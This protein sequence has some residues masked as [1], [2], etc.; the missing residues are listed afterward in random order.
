MA[1]RAAQCMQGRCIRVPRRMLGWSGAVAHPDA[2]AGGGGPG[3]FHTGDGRIGG[4]FEAS[5]Q[6]DDAKPAPKE[7]NPPPATVAGAIDGITLSVQTDFVDVEIDA[8]VLADKSN[9]ANVVAETTF[10]TPKV[11]DAFF[12]TEDDGKTV[13]KATKKL[14]WRGTVEIQVHYGAKVAAT[15]LACYGRGTTE[16]DIANGDITL[17]FHESCHIIHM[18]AYLKAHA[19]PTP[20]DIK[21]GMDLQKAQALANQYI[22]DVEAY[23]DALRSDT[24]KTVDETGHTLSAVEGGAECYLHELPP[25]GE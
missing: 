12:D 11:G 1:K 20:P 22:K 24:K 9:V 14:K 6:E 13:K 23:A 21:A 4:A 2:P 15:D 5:D 10:T 7:P 3:Y 25:E 18:K 19:L 8:K 17:G 16:S